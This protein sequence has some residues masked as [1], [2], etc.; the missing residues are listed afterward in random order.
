MPAMA[1]ELPED[2]EI[3]DAASVAEILENEDYPATTEFETT[4][5]Y[6]DFTA[7]GKTF[8][9]VVLRFEPDEPAFH[10]G[11]KIVLA[12]TAEG[13][14]SINSFLRT[15][16]DEEG[17]GAWLARRGVT[18][19]ALARIGRWNFFANDR[20]GE[21]DDIPL[22]DRMPIF[23]Q[24]QE[25]YWDVDD[26]TNQPAGGLSSSTGSREVR[27]A[28]ADSELR[29]YLIAA[30]PA[31]VVDGLEAGLRHALSDDERKESLL[32][33]WG[34]STGGAFMW[35]LADRVEPDGFLNWGASPTG[36]GYFYG[37]M[38]EDGWEWL[39]GES[40][41]RIRGRGR[42]DFDYYNTKADPAT[43]DERWERN[44]S[45]PRFKGVEDSLMFFNI[46][47]LAQHAVELYE[48][49]FLPATKRQAGYNA[50]F[51]E[52]VEVAMPGDYLN[53]I[54][55]WDMYGT[56]DEVYPYDGA[57]RARKIQEPYTGPHSIARI[58]GFNH[59]IGRNQL[60]VIGSVWLRAIESG[61]F[62]K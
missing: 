30:T 39:Y 50:L 7:N 25:E 26:F 47:A 40:A 56:E 16:E 59:S 4:L 52:I 32:F 3:L 34:F 60:P 5:D 36:L 28:A 41:L 38:L 21:W 20:S 54:P 14:S 11:K 17:I 61:Y 35:P 29:D 33:Y 6:V 1:W 12:A 9:Q 46:A 48:S 55:V 23:S 49:D 51:E 18:V 44:L 53:G 10:E 62:D 19:V 37:S 58:E 24:H 13:S 2:G 8:T 43:K 22:Q 31:A 15:D 27:Y 45:E 57:Q 42:E